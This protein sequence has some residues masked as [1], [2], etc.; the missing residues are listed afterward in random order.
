MDDPP[1]LIARMTLA[2]WVAR[3]FLSLLVALLTIVLILVFLVY[4][5]VAIAGGADLDQLS[6]CVE[7]RVRVTPPLSGLLGG[8][9]EI[10]LNLS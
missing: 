1:P 5:V 4:L 3:Q 8:A 10:I 6:R 2:L 7:E 9:I